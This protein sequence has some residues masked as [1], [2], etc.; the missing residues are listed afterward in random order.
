MIELLGKE[1]EVITADIVYKGVLIE[2]GENEIYLQS[3]DGWITV[4]VDKV[5][6]VRAAG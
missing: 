3:R 5:A 4:P 2:V 1:V 6:D